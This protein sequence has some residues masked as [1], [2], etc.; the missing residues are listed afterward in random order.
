MSEDPCLILLQEAGD[1]F[2]KL[3]C[4]SAVALLPVL[5]PYAHVWAEHVEP[6]REGDGSQ[7]SAEWMPFGGSHYT[8]LIRL[9]HACR[10]KESLLYLCKS[11][12]GT[13]YRIPTAEDYAVLLEIQA[14]CAAFWENLGSAIDNFAHAWDDARRILVGNAKNV[15]ANGDEPISGKTISDVK[16]KNLNQAFAR[17]TQYIHW[18]LVPK[19]LEDGRVE[20]N[21]RHYDDEKTVWLPEIEE[22][23]ALDVQIQQ[24]WN[25]VLNELSSAWWKLFSWLQSKDKDHAVGYESRLAVTPTEPSASY[26]APPSGTES[27]RT[28]MET[29]PPPSGS[30]L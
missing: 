17:R 15:G 22:I 5:H 21:L 8:A 27:I 14:V 12:D 18:R 30:F 16:Y 24:V 19:R 3:I 11:I 23:K 29:P 6:R 4:Q 13:K 10:A 28:D 9:Y 20:F 26:L 2:E 1:P 25:D 7:I